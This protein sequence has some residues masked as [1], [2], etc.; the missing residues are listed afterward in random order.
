MMN[1]M[2]ATP[3]FYHSSFMP[4]QSLRGQTK[5]ITDVFRSE[6]G[7]VLIIPD[8]IKVIL[9]TCFIHIALKGMTAD[10]AKEYCAKRIWASCEMKLIH[11]IKVNISN[12]TI[13]SLANSQKQL[14]CVLKSLMVPLLPQ[15]PVATTD[16]L[17]PFISYSRMMFS[18]MH[19]ASFMAIQSWASTQPL[20]RAHLDGKVLNELKIHKQQWENA[21]K[22]CGTYPLECYRLLF[23]NGADIDTSKLKILRYCAINWRRKSG[24]TWA[25][26]AAV[27]DA[28]NDE[29]RRLD[30]LM[31][32]VVPVKQ[33]NV[34]QQDLIETARSF[35]M[36]V[37]DDGSVETVNKF[38]PMERLFG[39]FEQFGNQ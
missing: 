12:E 9:W 20:T 16:R 32:Q 33:D 24:N 30:A 5:Y 27:T 18:G 1:E 21:T 37:N 23:P 36:P 22:A 25:N 14:L 11:E 8:E 3:H 26:F 28:G 15:V 39:L 10:K 2:N 38:A 17:Y 4:M 6:N 13:T 35:G 29:P 34:V 19:M 7:E 31:A